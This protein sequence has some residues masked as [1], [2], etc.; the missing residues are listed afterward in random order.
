MQ[1]FK[2]QNFTGGNF[3]FPGSQPN[4]N[5]PMFIQYNN[6]PMGVDHYNGH[7][8]IT[9]PRRREGIPSTLNVI[10][11]NANSRNK[12]PL[13]TPYP[14]IETNVL[15]VRTLYSVFR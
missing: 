7:L 12:S 9:M 4:Q 5:S 3:V 1:V 2:F 14:D 8:F 6:V 15:H 13:L 10:N 11:L